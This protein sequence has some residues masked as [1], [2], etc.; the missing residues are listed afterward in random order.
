MA[1]RKS[2]VNALTSTKNA[3]N[4]L[5]RAKCYRARIFTAEYE[6]YHIIAAYGIQEF[7]RMGEDIYKAM[8]EGKRYDAIRR[9]ATR[10]SYNPAT[11]EFGTLLE[12]LEAA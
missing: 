4:G 12:E 9:E 11:D 6:I 2:K 8:K 3:K 5:P 1:A 10:M 7:A